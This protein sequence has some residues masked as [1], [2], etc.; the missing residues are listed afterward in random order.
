MAEKLDLPVIENLESGPKRLSMD[1][2]LEFVR[3]N[4]QLTSDRK[5]AR[6]MKKLESVRTVFSLSSPA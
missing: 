6:E 5:R 3:S 1:E 4:T 2:Y